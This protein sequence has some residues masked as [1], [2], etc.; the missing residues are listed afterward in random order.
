MKLNCKPYLLYTI[1]LMLLIVACN[2]DKVSTSQTYQQLTRSPWTF[3][4]NKPGS[5]IGFPL[6]FPS[7]S[8][9]HVPPNT[10]FTG[11]SR[12][13]MSFNTNSSINFT[14][15]RT[16]VS[17]SWELQQNL[18]DIKIHKTDQGGNSYYDI[19]AIK[20]ISDTLLDIRVRDISEPETTD[21]YWGY[22]YR[23][24]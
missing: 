17:Y 6:S 4:L 3:Y 7:Y 14:P 13:S 18:T 12:Y 5:P 16:G 1:S 2:K 22:K 10:G 24:P 19:W 20:E 15:E 8:V 21:N 9:Y 23:R 11:L